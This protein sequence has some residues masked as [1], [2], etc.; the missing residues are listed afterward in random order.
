MNRQMKEGVVIRP[1]NAENWAANRR[2]YG[3]PAGEQTGKN[4]KST[5]LYSATP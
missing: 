3:Q 1:L 2:F 5:T 4:Q